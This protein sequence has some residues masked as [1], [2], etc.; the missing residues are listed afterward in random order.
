MRQGHETPSLEGAA[1]SRRTQG[2][3]PR[4]SGSSAVPLCHYLHFAW[5]GLIKQGQTGGIIPSQRFLIRKMIEPVPSDYRGHLIELGAGN[6]AL[7]L[8][9]A[10]KCPDAHI[11]ACEIN[12]VLAQDMESNITA[13]GLAGR[14]KVVSCSAEHVLS[15]VIPQKH[16]KPDY[17]ISGIP[18]GNLGRRRAFAFVDL[19]GHTLAQTGLYVQFQHSLLDRK[20]LR[21]CFSNVRIVPVLFN[22]PP[23]VVYYAR[24]PKCGFR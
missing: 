20:N 13:A 14:A 24:Q 4:R 19:I 23:A 2:L 15:E 1:F 12:P 16:S 18:L 21:S 6:G 22:F 8:R 10:A 5:A 7:T 9:L 3:S 11:L 17:I